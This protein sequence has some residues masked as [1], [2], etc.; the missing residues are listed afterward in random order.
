MFKYLKCLI[1]SAFL[2]IPTKESKVLLFPTNVKPCKSALNKCNQ[3]LNQ[4]HFDILEHVCD[5]GSGGSYKQLLMMA[6]MTR[7][8]K[9]VMITSD[10][11]GGLFKQ[12]LR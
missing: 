5:V 6:M 10:G 9:K 4:T 3:D 1:Q 7:T 8:R 11:G 12:L 2:A